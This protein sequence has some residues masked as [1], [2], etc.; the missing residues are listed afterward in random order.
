MPVLNITHKLNDAGNDVLCSSYNSLRG[1]KYSQDSFKT[2]CP[3]CLAILNAKYS[4]KEEVKL[5]LKPINERVNDDE[6][7]N[8]KRC[9]FLNYKGGLDMDS[10]F[11]M[12]NIIK[13]LQANDLDKIHELFD[14]TFSDEMIIVSLKTILG[15]FDRF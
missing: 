3:A 14:N 2:T 8:L 6:F 9:L 10:K 15:A 13:R 12:N 11:I 5:K 4:P 7:K 1:D